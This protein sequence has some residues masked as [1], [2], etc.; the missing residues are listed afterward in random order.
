MNKLIEDTRRR[1]GRIQEATKGT[2]S[3]RRTREQA[4]RAG[5]AR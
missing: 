4:E 3:A 2:E 1:I 5:G